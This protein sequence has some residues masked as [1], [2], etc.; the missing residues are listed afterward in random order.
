MDGLL[1]R[2]EAGRITSDQGAIQDATRALVQMEAHRYFHVQVRG[3]TLSVAENQ[4]HLER[5]AR[6]DGVFILQSSAQDLD[7]RAVVLAYRQLLWVERAIRT[8]ESFLRVRPLYHF[9]ERRIRAPSSCAFWAT[10]WRTT[11]ASGCCRA[12]PAAAH[13]PRW[14]PWNRCAWSAKP[15]WCANAATSLHPTD[16]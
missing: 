16:S 12:T 9:T 4:E 2:W 15:T 7:P 5:E 3:Q 14:R 1:D 10:C 13:G 8:L 6:L 11:C